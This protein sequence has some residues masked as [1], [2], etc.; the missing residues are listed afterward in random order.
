MYILYI[1]KCLFVL[2][3]LHGTSAHNLLSVCLTSSP[4][5]MEYVQVERWS[6]TIENDRLQCN[7]CSLSEETITPPRGR[8]EI[9]YNQIPS[10]DQCRSRCFIG[11]RPGRGRLRPDCLKEISTCFDKG[12]H[13]LYIWNTFGWRDSLFTQRTRVTS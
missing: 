4:V 8:S 1:P 10:R 13:S 7:P 12:D 6:Q 2:H 11:R 5:D 9:R 3:I